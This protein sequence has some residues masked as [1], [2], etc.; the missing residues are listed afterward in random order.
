[1]RRAAFGVFFERQR[2][3]QQQRVPAIDAQGAVELVGKFDGF[4]GVAALAGQRDRVRA[5]G[6]GVIGGDDFD[7]EVSTSSKRHS[8]E[9]VIPNAVSH[10]QPD[11]PILESNRREILDIS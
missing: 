2:L 8:L 5:Q 6:D 11:I 4:A 7:L 3:R 9:I 1:M 10:P